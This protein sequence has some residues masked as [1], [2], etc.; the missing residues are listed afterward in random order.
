MH[1]QITEWRAQVPF[2][3]SLSGESHQFRNRN[4]PRS[5]PPAASCGVLF[6]RRFRVFT[7]SFL[8]NPLGR[9]PIPQDLLERRRTQSSADYHPN[10]PVP[11][12]WLVLPVCCG[13]FHS[14]PHRRMRWIGPVQSIHRQ[15]NQF[16]LP[17][18]DFHGGEIDS[19]LE[20]QSIADSINRTRNRILDQCPRV[21]GNRKFAQEQ[22]P[23]WQIDP[24]GPIEVRFRIIMFNDGFP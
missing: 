1:L 18:S 19:V 17:I 11:D 16:A 22:G 7:V 20:R 2:S 15:G 4:A 12:R 14:M 5:P 13:C 21:G 24:F 9:D 8:G 10:F 3:V 23:C 6:C